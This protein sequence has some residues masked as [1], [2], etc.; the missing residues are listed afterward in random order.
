MRDR[1]RYWVCQDR[2]TGTSKTNK[3]KERGRE[4]GSG[5]E[6]ERDSNIQTQTARHRQRKTER[7]REREIARECARIERKPC[8]CEA[9]TNILAAGCT[10]SNSLMM[11][12]A[13]L[14]TNNL[15]RWLM[16]ILFLPSEENCWWEHSIHLTNNLSLFPSRIASIL[17]LMLLSLSLQHQSRV[18]RSPF[19]KLFLSA[20]SPPFI[21]LPHLSRSTSLD[22]LPRSHQRTAVFSCSFFALFSSWLSRIQCV[23]V[24]E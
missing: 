22:L 24:N 14:V 18:V 23:V 9:K 20:S 17:L 1:M 10:T 5:R 15:P 13:S 19:Q 3:Q 8:I 4:R 12:A 11:V 2:F 21:P 6:R 16:T 7:E